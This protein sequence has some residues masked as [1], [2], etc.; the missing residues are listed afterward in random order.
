MYGFDTKEIEI[1]ETQ[2]GI[3]SKKIEIDTDLHCCIVM[4][5][6]NKKLLTPI[7]NKIVDLLLDHIDKKDTYNSFSVTLEN[8]N[9]FIKNLRLKEDPLNDLSIIIWILDKNT[10][11]FAK[12][13]E[14]SA[15]LINKE[16]D[17]LE[18]TDGNA[19]VE[20]FDF[21]STGNLS[22]HEKIIFSNIRFENFLNESDFE[23][24]TQISNIENINTN[25]I[26]I[27]QEEKIEQNLSLLTF[28]YLWDEETKKNSIHFSVQKTKYFFLKILDN[29]I[30]KEIFAHAL[31]VKEK[32]E[33]KGKIVK[34]VLFWFGI[35]ISAIFLFKIIS[36]W[37]GTTTWTPS[38]QDYKLKLL[39][40]REFI[41]VANQNIWNPE[42]FDLHIN[43]AEALALEVKE[44][45][46][47]LNDV[48]ALLNDISLIKKEFNGIETFNTTPSNLLMTWDFQDGIR[49]LELNKQFYVIWKSA[50][51]GPI[52]TG[53]ETKTHIF[54]ELDVQ[55]EFIDATLSG[56]NI[57][58]HTRKGRMIRFSRD[59]KFAYVSVLEQSTWDQSRFIEWFN[60]NI[61]LTNKESNQIIMHSPALSGFNSWV[62]YLN[63]EDS[64]MLGEIYSVWIDGWIYML[65]KDLKLYKFFRSP[66]YRLE[67]IVLNK[68]PKNYQIEN[69]NTNVKIIA[70]ANLNYVYL[71]LNNKIWIFQPNTR[72]VTDVKSLQY[73]GQIEWWNEPFIS[74]EII[75]DG[76]I[77]VLTKSGIYKIG[78]EIK[79]ENL[80]LR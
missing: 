4:S 46:L 75:R 12:I 19:K 35:F 11:H 73:L 39:Q 60:G 52:I 10:L 42:A 54:E 25:L 80:L 56:E 69:N 53:T 8:I 23:E 70:K 36:I 58:I 18:V 38:T 32:I 29:N 41:Q 13:W 66:R 50:V 1:D 21:I 63:E 17:I 61:Y 15:Y 31:I 72:V 16:K 78:F 68:L 30:A 64:K 27:A 48:D 28:E 77:N 79:D 22:K 57:I 37:I 34:N 59:Q 47:F 44:K 6:K 65:N 67:S 7:L 74:F 45:Q 5:A 14:A 62:S 33:S 43:Q 20:T 51:Y 76:E 40:S 49:I 24:M 71:Y 55:D 26:Q 3:L 2:N 9:Y